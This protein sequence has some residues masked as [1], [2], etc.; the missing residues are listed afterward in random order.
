MRYL[1]SLIF[2]LVGGAMLYFSYGQYTSSKELIDRG[3]RAGGIVIDNIEQYDEDGTTYKPLVEFKVGGEAYQFTSEVSSNPAVYQ[4]GD[5]IEVLYP[6]DHPEQGRI[7]DFWSL[8]FVTVLLG[9]FG[10]VFFGVG[11][12]TL[13]YGLRNIPSFGPKTPSPPMSGKPPPQGPIN[14]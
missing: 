5:R 12:G 6:K 14:I 9:I 7:N 10:V 13:W 11:G 3:A 2:L 4:K 1:F 8:W